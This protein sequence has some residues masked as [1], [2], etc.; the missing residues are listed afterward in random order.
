[1]IVGGEAVVHY[2]YARLTGDVD[3]FY[4]VAD[5]NCKKLFAALQEFWK[6]DVPGIAGAGELSEPGAI[7]QFGVPP[8]R[9]DLLN[10][11]DGVTFVECWGS[12]IEV[13]IQSPEGL[14]PV[15]YIGLK[16]L[17]KNKAAAGRDKDVDD[18]RFLKRV[19]G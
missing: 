16:E 5:D 9:I 6:Q 18:L 12:R 15:P 2:G 10:G 11:I 1:M 4:D 19:G 8:N 17:I 7:F 3:V 14:I 13:Q